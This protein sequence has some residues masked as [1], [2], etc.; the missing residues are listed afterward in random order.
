MTPNLTLSEASVGKIFRARSGV[1]F[2]VTAIVATNSETPFRCKSGAGDII[3]VAKTGRYN[4]YSEFDSSLDLL[5]EVP[6]PT[7]ELNITEA[8]IGRKFKTRDGRTFVIVDMGGTETYPVRVR[9]DSGVMFSCGPSGHF[10]KSNHPDGIDLVER[11]PAPAP[12]H[13][14][15]ITEADIGQKFKTRDGRTVRVESVN[16]SHSSHP[17]WSVIGV[18]ERDGREFY[19]IDGAWTS[20]GAPNENDLVERLPKTLR[21]LT[22]NLTANDIGR[23][24]KT[25]AGRITTL[26]KIYDSEDLHRFVTTRDDDN[27]LR[28]TDAGGNWYAS[29][30]ESQFDLVERLP[31]PVTTLLNA[32]SVGKVYKTTNGDR[33]KIIAIEAGSPTPY[34]AESLDIQFPEHLAGGLTY[35]ASGELIP[36]YQ[37]LLNLIAEADEEEDSPIPFLSLLSRLGA[38]LN[39]R[40]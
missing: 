31:E 13:P 30:G 22:P 24:F 33:Y 36:G 26:T 9:A 21:G 5:S 16:S 20:Y 7:L 27:F 39:H 10:W 23:Q 11:L 38:R 28:T 8:D 37:S 25:R 15:V 35:T 17:N 4:P 14:M 32:S 40:A 19:Q 12:A 34:R 1:A 6:A 2:H 18:T 3:H 29:L